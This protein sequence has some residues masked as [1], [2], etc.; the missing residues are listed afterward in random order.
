MKKILNNKTLKRV[1]AKR[2]VGIFLMLLLLLLI[3]GLASKQFFTVSNLLTISKQSSMVFI[4]GVGLTMV[5]ILGGIDLSIGYVAGLSGMIAAGLIRDQMPMII[6][7]LVPLLVGIAIGFINGLLI[8][9]IGITDFIVTLSTMLVAHG[10][11]FVYSKGRSIFENMTD[12]FRFIGGGDILGIPFPIIIAI[13]VFIFGYLLLSKFRLGTYMYATGGSK[14]AARLSGINVDRVKIIA[15][16]IS[17][18]TA[19]IA[20]VIMTSRL[21][22]GQPTAGDSFLFD[23]I[24]GVVLGGTSLAGGEGSVIG[25]AIGMLIIGAIT[26]GLTQLGASFYWQEVIKGAI[27]LLAVGFTAIKDKRVANG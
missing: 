6:V 17:G 27:I 10:L 2:E 12:E 1:F 14:E 8:S 25:T 18:F 26:N 19:A 16:S 22:S 9:K 23:A 15:Y 11:I 5:V 3:F 7:I 24:G 13:V 4:M 20:G 21:G